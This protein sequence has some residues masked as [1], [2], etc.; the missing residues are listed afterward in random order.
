MTKSSLVHKKVINEVR[1]TVHIS[2]GIHIG[3]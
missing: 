2:H 1:K 3:H